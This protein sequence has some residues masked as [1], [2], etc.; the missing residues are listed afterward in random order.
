VATF[1]V[2]AF[3]GAPDVITALILA[4]LLVGVTVALPAVLRTPFPWRL[5]ITAGNGLALILMLT[6]LVRGIQNGTVAQLGR[7]V[8]WALAAVTRSASQPAGPAGPAGEVLPDI[9]VLMPE[10]Y[11]RA[12]TL[13][14]LWGY[15][16]G[17][18]LGALEDRGFVVSD[19]SRANYSNSLL[20][21]LTMFQARH[22]EAIPALDAVRR[23]TLDPH[24]A[25]R[26]AL[27]SGI[28][29]DVL[30]RYGYEL[31]AASSGYE[32]STVRNADRFVDTGQLNDFE[33]TL[34]DQSAI[35]RLD[36]RWFLDLFGDQLRARVHAE[37][38][39]VAR[40]ATE[41][42]SRPRFVLVH[43]PSPHAPILFGA[44]GEPVE[45]PEKRYAN[46]LGDRERFIRL[47]SAQ[48]GYVNRLIL[49]AVDAL[50]AAAARPMV[51]IVMSDEGL[52]WYNAGFDPDP[53]TRPL[54]LLT[55]L[56]AARAPER[57]DLFGPSITPVNVLPILFERYLG[58]TLPRQSDRGF[59]SSDAAPFDGIEIPN[60]DAEAP[61]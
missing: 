10:D 49:D 21:L 43:I 14:R 9:V 3:L 59:L 18:F 8:G 35:G 52:G 11:P 19:R 41:R 54:L 37:F 23:G 29:L 4:L 51:V 24:L 36:R 57:D 13:A 42:S 31:V 20:T 15:D 1:A 5:V 61:P 6:L 16:N 22:I 27:N 56:F 58:E 48:L 38:D 2:V 60:T 39:F 46:D 44:N 7:D 25:L 17:P 26:D 45:V 47:Y 33:L 53:E 32:Q 50:D 55:N 28:T 12:D 34:L 30:R 40:L